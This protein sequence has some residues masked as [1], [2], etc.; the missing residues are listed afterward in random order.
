MSG[1]RGIL[2]YRTGRKLCQAGYSQRATCS[3]RVLR[4]NVVSGHESCGSVWMWLSLLDSN[5]EDR[6][7]CCMHEPSRSDDLKD[8]ASGTPGHPPVKTCNA[9]SYEN[10]QYYEETGRC[11][12]RSDNLS[13]PKGHGSSPRTSVPFYSVH[14]ACCCRPSMM[15]ITNFSTWGRMHLC[16][17]SGR[18]GT[19]GNISSSLITDIF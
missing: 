14:L 16:C 9:C 17:P 1:S 4:H 3:R 2:V 18:R 10:A 8:S 13:A 5:F 15:E 7:F 11:P 19:R 12:L 6:T